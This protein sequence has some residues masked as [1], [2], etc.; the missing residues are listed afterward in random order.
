MKIASCLALLTLSL[1][2]VTA[3]DWPN[4]R[5]PNHDGIS[6][7]TG[8][9]TEWPA[10]GPKVLWKAKVGLGFSAVVVANGAAF[11]QG[12]AEDKDTIFCFDATTGETKW[13]HTYAAPLDAKYYEGGTSATPTVDGDRVYTVS[14]RGVIHCLN[15]ADGKVIWTKDL[16]E[17]LG[18]KIPE[19]GFAGSVLIEG[20]VAILNFGTAG[21]ALDKK[22]GKVV[23][24]SGPDEAGYSTPVPIDAGGERAVMIAIKQDV[25]AVKIKDGK[26]LWRFPWK[27]QY[28]VN[29]AN[30]ILSGS[31]VF[32]SSGYNRGAG[33][34]D[35]SKKPAEKIWENKNLRNH[36][37]TSVLWQ[38]HLYGVDE[39]QLRCV[40]FDTGEVKWTDKVSGKGSLIMADGKLIILSERGELLVAN[41]SPAG[42]KPISR[43]QVVGG[44]CWSAPTLANGKIY[45]RTGPGD[46]VCV[47]VSGK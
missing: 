13:K 23:W 8:W 31:K 45:V 47:D 34:F 7:E 11:T 42:F 43:A 5:G 15:A 1:V 9:A 29:A 35:I 3:A 36:F 21:T 38:G 18:A 39:N 46:L 30:P 25:V 33:V 2:A 40:V 27:T 16:K 32:I 10:N 20:D 19:W 28:D 44:K 26:E 12:N 41:P 14:K 6:K 24:T 37:A 22:T 17:E 4:Y